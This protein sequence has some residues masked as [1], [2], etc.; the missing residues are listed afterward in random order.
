ME[1]G[2]PDLLYRKLCRGIM[3][4]HQRV[5]EETKVLEGERVLL[6]QAVPEDAALLAKWLNDPDTTRWLLVTPP[7]SLAW[8]RRWLKA[9]MEEPCSR[10]FMLCTREFVPIGTVSLSQIS[11]AHKRAR[12]GISIF[13]SEFRARGLGTEAMQL[14]LDYAF[15]SLDLNR[16]ELD[17]FE[18]NV[19]AERSYA[20]CGFVREG[21]MREA[22]IKDGKPINSV[23]MSVLRH[24]WAALHQ[25][26]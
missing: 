15:F 23:L 2:E 9:E 21:V 6:R 1:W 11:H 8:V 16:V 3:S 22:Y 19:Y 14:V 18:H 25:A 4:E 13:E 7:V 10:L 24:E 12:V 26:H 20:K 5:T 17:V